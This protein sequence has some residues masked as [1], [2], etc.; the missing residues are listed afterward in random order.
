VALVL[1]WLLAPM[2]SDL[3]A[4][5]SE[6]L[7]LDMN[8]E[9]RFLLTPGY[10]AAY[11]AGILVL[12]TLCGLLPAWSASRCEPIDVIKGTLRRKNKM[13]FSK[14]FIVAQN[15]LAVFLIA[16]A[17]VMELQMKHMVERPTHSQVETAITSTIMRRP[18]TR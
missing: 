12:G 9:L 5:R 6:F 11:V 7:N 1:A 8:V 16:L 18:T 3:L 10:I 17:F 14:V 13:V 15:A 4:K 2:L